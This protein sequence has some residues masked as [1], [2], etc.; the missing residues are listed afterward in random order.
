LPCYR[1]VGG[2]RVPSWYFPIKQYTMIVF[3]VPWNKMLGVAFFFKSTLPRPC[4]FQFLHAIQIINTIAISFISIIRNNTVIIIIDHFGLIEMVGKSK[5]ETDV[6]ARVLF[7]IKVSLP[8]QIGNN[9][10]LGG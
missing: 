6:Q 5:V 1:C 8:R 9:L 7:E 3:S 2:G 4:C 10:T